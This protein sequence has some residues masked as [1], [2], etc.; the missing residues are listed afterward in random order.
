MLAGDDAPAPGRRAVVYLHLSD[1]A[2]LGVDPVAHNETSGRAV[3]TAA[4]RDWLA[5]TDTHV[6][7]KP[8]LDLA[9]HRHT[10]AYAVPDA[11]REQTGL[12]HPTCVFPWCTRPARICDRDHLEPWNLDPDTG[13]P[14]CSCNV[15]PLCRHHHL[16][17]THSGWAYRRLD[18]RHRFRVTMDLGLIPC[19]TGVSRPTHR[20]RPTRDRDAR[21]PRPRRPPR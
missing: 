10:D 21:A 15:H 8:V 7:V 5:R 4:V 16:L 11:L 3:L 18:T 20:A 17:K 13:G 19:A 9:E 2:I 12:L 6:T 14:T 1:A